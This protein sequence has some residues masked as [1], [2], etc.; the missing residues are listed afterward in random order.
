M[1]YLIHGGGDTALSWSTVGRANNILD[2]LL[3]EKKARPMIVVMPSGWTP[4]G[5]QVMTLGRDE[6]SVQRR[7]DEGHHPVRAGELPHSR[8]PGEPRV[9]G[10]LDGRHP[11]A[12]H[13]A[14]QSRHVPLRRCHELGMDDRS[15][16]ASSSTRRKPR[17]SRPTTISSSCSGGAGAKPT[18]PARMALR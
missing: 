1:L 11:D 4:S 5:G 12:E 18:L 9:V 13:R 6:G 15:R 7:D 8:D 17:R 3:A 2:N 16:I 10:A 14:P